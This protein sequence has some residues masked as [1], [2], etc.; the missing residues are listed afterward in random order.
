MTPHD[1]GSNYANVAWIRDVMLYGKHLNINM[2][3]SY[4]YE[5]NC[6]LVPERITS[7]GIKG[8]LLFGIWFVFYLV[9]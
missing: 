1:S 5:L 6:C 3:Y 2:R 4:C 8:K 9:I 7:D